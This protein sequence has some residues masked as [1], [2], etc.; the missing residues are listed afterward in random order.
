MKTH[1]IFILLLLLTMACSCAKETAKVIPPDPEADA[2]Q[3]AKEYTQDLSRVEEGWIVKYQPVK[4][5]AIYTIHMKFNPDNTTSILSDYPDMNYLQEQPKVNYGL[6]GTL[7]TE[8]T[9]NTYCVWHKMYDD[10]GGDYKFSITRQTDG[11]FTLQPENKAEIR[12]YDLVKAD[13]KAISELEENI[14]KQKVIVE[15]GHKRIQIRNMLYNFMEDHSTYFKNISLQKGETNIMHGAVSFDTDGNQLKIIYRD[16]NKLTNLSGKYQITEEGISL[17]NP[18]T[19]GEDTISEFKLQKKEDSDDII[20]TSTKAGISG[21]VTLA[22]TPGVIPYPDIAT[23]YSTNYTMCQLH[24]CK[25]ET[26]NKAYNELLS[27]SDITTFF[28]FSGSNGRSGWCI[29]D[30]RY[31]SDDAWFYVSVATPNAYTVQYTSYS[32]NKPDRYPNSLWTLYCEEHIVLYKKKTY[33]PGDLGS[34][35]LMDPED[36][37]NQL[38]IRV[39]N[40]QTNNT[41]WS[42]I[43]WNNIAYTD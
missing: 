22:K 37:E 9:F 27:S 4:Q 16:N 23:H 21:E 40:T 19:F 14:A 29:R 1:I 25:G 12:F 8:L 20:I 11:N 34:I 31:P 36:N 15:A 6:T 35:I 32:V 13:P 42:A 17:E 43:D 39:P 30:S 24:N 41:V 5:G 18:V 7:N 33:R 38:I 3:L 2:W 26:L 10:L 28:I